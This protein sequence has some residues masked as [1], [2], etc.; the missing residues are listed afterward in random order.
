MNLLTKVRK[1]TENDLEGILGLVR[2][3]AEYEKAPQAVTAGIESYRK[4]FKEGIFD[5]IVAENRDGQILGMVL[6]YKAWSTWK[7][8][9]LYL[10]DFVVK[11]NVRGQGVG[12]VLFDALILEAKRLNCVM[13]KWQV[14]DWNIPAIQFYEKYDTVFDKEWWN[15]K[16]YF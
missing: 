8:K 14:L 5:A 7:G 10:E 13:M 16:I 11:E 2:D 6:F 9:M 3:L 1:A 4:N 12:K 15:G